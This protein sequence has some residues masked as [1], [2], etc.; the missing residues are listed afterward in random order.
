MLITGTF[1]IFIF[2]SC[3][4]FTDDTPFKKYDLLSTD[5]EK[6]SLLVVANEDETE[7]K[8]F[9][10]ENTILNVG[11]IQH[12][13]SLEKTPDFLLFDQTNM[14]YQTYDEQDLIDFLVT[15]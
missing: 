2:T 11:V 5:E 14:V 9:L 13:Y 7:W 15:N 8:E 4:Y 12:Q 3:S 10:D 1:L 6:F